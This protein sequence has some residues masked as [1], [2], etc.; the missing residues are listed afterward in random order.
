VKTMTITAKDVQQLRRA[1]G[2]GMMDAKRA[3]EEAGGD[4]TRAA[5]ILREKGNA[6]A[7]KRRDRAQTEGAVGYYLHYQSGRPVIGVLVELA[8]ETDFVAKSEEF[9]AAA[10]DIAMH[11]AATRPRWVTRDDVPE[12]IL[13]K[14]KS[15]IEAQ[16]RHEGKPDHIIDKIVEGRV[17]SFYE[18]NVLY[19][20]T[21]IRPERF[22]G[23]IGEMVQRMAAT[24][25]ENIS[26]ARISRLQVGESGE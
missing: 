22:E 6:D 20:Q 2:S 23:T 11:V 13:A 7:A 10:N 1:T 5:D 19:D 17:G 21:Y 14:E 15:L 16:A 25:E 24:M 3:L 18:D 9:Q 8:S 12:E 4:M 26:V